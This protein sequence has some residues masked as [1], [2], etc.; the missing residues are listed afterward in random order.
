MTSAL[1]AFR[2]RANSPTVISSGTV[3]VMA[4]ALRSAAMRLSLSASVS[5]FALRGLPRRWLFWLIFCFAATVSFFTLSY[6]RRSYFSLYLS[7]L[8]LTVLVSTTRRRGASLAASCAGVLLL[9]WLFCAGRCGL[10]CCAFWFLLLPLLLRRSLFLLRL[11]LLF[12]FCFFGSCVFLAVFSL[13]FSAVFSAGFSSVFAAL[14]V[15][16]Y[17]SKFCAA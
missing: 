7:M 5:R 16:K 1:V 2:R 9:G 4:F 10:F 14:R 17:A 13:G 3:M 15:A 6:A 8:T 12:T 11:L